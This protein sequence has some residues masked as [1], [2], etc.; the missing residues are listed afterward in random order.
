LAIAD[1]WL[2]VDSTKTFSI[3]DENYTIMWT[4][5]VIWQGRGLT[6]LNSCLWGVD[7]TLLSEV[8]S[9]AAASIF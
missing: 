3:N 1:A 9:G 4:W 8:Q 5:V 7:D 6:F 2:M